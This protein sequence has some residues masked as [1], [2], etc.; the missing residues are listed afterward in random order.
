M[1]RGP[2]LAQTSFFPS[3]ERGPERR[4][5]AS[6]Q[7]HNPRLVGDTHTDF[8]TPLNFQVEQSGLDFIRSAYINLPIKATFQGL[9]SHFTI[10]GHEGDYPVVELSA[11]RSMALA[12]RPEYVFEKIST[13]VNEITSVRF[14]HRVGP[15]QQDTQKNPDKNEYR[16]SDDFLPYFKSRGDP[17]TVFRRAHAATTNYAQCATNRR[18]EFQRDASYFPTPPRSN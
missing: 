16:E 11:A 2:Q 8:Q 9:V 10:Q 1:R 5:V 4:K 7:C 6:Y 17:N 12:D 3:A 15:V 13:R 18:N 14:P